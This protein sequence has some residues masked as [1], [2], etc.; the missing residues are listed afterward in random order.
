MFAT[1]AHEEVTKRAGAISGS[2]PMVEPLLVQGPVRMTMIIMMVVV[3]MIVMLVVRS[4][5]NISTQKKL[6]K[7]LFTLFC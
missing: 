4:S 3:V 6:F 1:M 7:I 5:N 2:R